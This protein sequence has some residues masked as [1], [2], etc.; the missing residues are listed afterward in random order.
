MTYQGV[1][2]LAEWTGQGLHPVSLELLSEARRLADELETQVT[3]F[4]LSPEEGEKVARSLI[5]HGADKVL[6]ACHEILNTFLDDVWTRL[7]VK[8]LE[9]ERPEIMLFSATSR[10]QA[11]APR[12]AGFMRLGLTAH[13]IGFEI[14]KE[15]RALVQIR[16]SFGENVMAKIVSLTKP[17]MAT[18]RPGVFPRAKEDPSREGKIEKVALSS[19][20]RKI[21]RKMEFL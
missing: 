4:F 16:P 20:E 2:I 7:I 6:W 15:D 5:K 18:V 17:Q 9:Q 8:M 14:R 21:F 11:V 19:L 1:A 10:G 13:C 3:A 12:V